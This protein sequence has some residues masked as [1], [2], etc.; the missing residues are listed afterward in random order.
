LTLHRGG[1]NFYFERELAEC[2]RGD[3]A[4]EE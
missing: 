1:L 3:A 4:A 2:E